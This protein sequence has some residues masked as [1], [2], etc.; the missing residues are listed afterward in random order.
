M[1]RDEWRGERRLV[2][3][4]EERCQILRREAWEEGRHVA[5]TSD[6]AG[7]HWCFGDCASWKA[8]C[9]AVGLHRISD[10]FI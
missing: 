4:A 10:D 2:E 3:E 9:D 6:V 8:A 1:L 7:C 5:W